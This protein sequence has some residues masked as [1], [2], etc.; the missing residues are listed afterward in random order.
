M[1]NQRVVMLELDGLFSTQYYGTSLVYPPAFVFW[2]TVGLVVSIGLVVS[3]L[4][5]LFA[6]SCWWLCGIA[7][8]N[9]H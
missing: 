3:D 8:A 1:E 6:I 4:F 2:D 9:G 7:L 5:H